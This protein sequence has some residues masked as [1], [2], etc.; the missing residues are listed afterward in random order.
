M[1]EPIRLGII[2]IG[3]AGYGMQCSEIKEKTDMFKIVAACDIIK[4]RTDKMNAEYGCATYENID[5]LIADENVELVSIATRSCDHFAHAVKVLKAGKNVLLEKP[6]C[7]TYEQALQLK[8]LASKE[9][10]PRIYA[11][12]NRRF[13][14]N[15][16]KI[17]EI[18]ASGILG[19][20]FEIHITRNGYSRRDDWQTLSQFGGGQLLNWGPHIIDQSL[21]LLDSPIKDMTSN[22]KHTVAGGD[23]EDHLT[24]TFLGENDRT[25]TMQISGGM[26]LPTPEY[27]VYGTKGSLEIVDNKIQL[28]YIDPAQKLDPPVADPGTPGQS[29]GATGTFAGTT[30]VEWVETTID[31]WHEDLSVIWEHMY[32]A[33]RDG[34]VYPIALEEAMQVIE[35]IT[36]VKKGTKFERKV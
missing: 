21:R 1:S 26:V 11:R 22:L 24:I 29:F 8:E 3:R 32:H 19:D 12:H 35:V 10:G 33:I 14:Y 2:G 28:Q 17:K 30:P 20:V 16:E 25:I 9:N 4:E 34:A 6:M 23:C 18:M 13:E 15:F 7:E 36:N 27:R 31:E 5:D